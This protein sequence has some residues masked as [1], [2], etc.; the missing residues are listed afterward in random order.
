MYRLE[1]ISTS[2]HVDSSKKLTEVP[3]EF[4]GLSYVPFVT[5]FK[6]EVVI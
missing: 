5:F 4:I 6:I 3:D 1:I 2:S